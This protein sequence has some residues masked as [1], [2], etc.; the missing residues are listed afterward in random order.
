MDNSRRLSPEVQKRF[1]KADSSR[2]QGE[3]A[4]VT[5]AFSRWRRGLMAAVRVWLP[6][7]RPPSA[8]AAVRR[9]LNWGRENQDEIIAFVTIVSVGAFL[10]LYHLDSIPSGGIH[11]D[12]ALGALRAHAILD[13]EWAGPFDPYHAFGAPAGWEFWM[14]GVIWLFGDSLFA[15]RMSMALL[16]IAAIPLAYFLFRA[17]DGKATAIIGSSLLAFSGWHLLFSRQA[18]PPVTM[19]T[20]ALLSGLFLVL[21][22]RSQKWW[23]F[24]LTGFVMALGLYMY[25]GY[26]YFLF[27]ASV[28]LAGW[29]VGQ[30]A[31]FAR[32]VLSLAVLSAAF[33]LT[34]LP[35]L[36]YIREHQDTY[37]RYPRSTSIFNS[38][39]YDGAS[40]FMERADVVLDSGRDFVR[41]LVFDGARDIPMLAVATSVLL[42]LGFLYAV[43]RW[44]EPGMALCLIL[45]LL[46][47]WA[48][49]LNP[50]GASIMLRRAIGVT[51]F[52][53][54]LAA[55]PLS[56][57]LR[58]KY[59]AAPPLKALVLAAAVAAVASVGVTNV[60]FYFRGYAASFDTRTNYEMV[61][62]SNFLADLPGD[63]YVY[64]YSTRWTFDYVIRQ[65]LAPDVE[66]ENRSGNWGS[67]FDLTPRHDR[68]IVYMFLGSLLDTS[69]DVERLYPGG[70]ASEFVD[71]H[72][73]VVYRAYELPRTADVSRELPEPGSPE[74]IESLTEGEGSNEARD[75]VRR[76]HLEQLR[77]ALEDYAEQTGSYP[78]TNNQLQ[79]LCVFRELDAG[80]AL[81]TILSE[82]P[83]DPL[84]SPGSNGYWYSSDG[85]SFLLVAQQESIE[86]EVIGCPDYIV[87]S[88]GGAGRY[89]VQVPKP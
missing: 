2:Q 69:A 74:A 14:A 35:M 40:G 37:F 80:C 22:L 1:T 16:A 27:G 70:Q 53:A 38:A 86:G 32:A 62:A 17:I 29:L 23:L 25:N 84:G 81:T 63:P 51:P 79:T 87:Q 66:G 52:I 26:F 11:G 39:R 57:A 59:L 31:A 34:A 71:E 72:E 8:R 78:D 44:R 28:V 3:N 75:E 24:P 45:F 5:R 12:E 50:G 13:R 83:A 68:D 30:R 41:L 46:I 82:L 54:F 7:I 42:G 19:T 55:L 47:P 10:R 20:T 48:A 33:F 6:P 9:L 60:N 73:T 88:A 65:Y 89:C 61:H 58:S 43:R 64:F 18:W 15:I 77:Q 67:D 85:S 4:G 21:T 49:I 76:L 56:A 36:T